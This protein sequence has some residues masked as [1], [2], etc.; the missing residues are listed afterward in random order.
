[1]RE[2]W[3]AFEHGVH[4]AARHTVLIG[5]LVACLT[6]A[7]ASAKPAPALFQLSIT[8]TAHAEW[9]HTGAVAAAGDCERTVRSEGIRN[10]SFR[11]A[12]STLVRVADGHVLAAKVRRLAGT[13]TL[14]GAN[15]TTDVCGVEVHEAIADCATTKRSFRGGT[16]DLASSRSP[17]LTFR[18]VRNVR[19]RTSSCPREPAQLARAPIGPVPASVPVSRATLSNDRLTRI[20]VTA[21]ARVKTT[22]GS[23]ESGTLNQRAVWKLE[24]RRVER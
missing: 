21:T 15:T 10:V 24:L 22:F 6:A 4:P 11:T 23:P 3:E 12:G 20:T 2:L 18:P 16:V 9:D 17:N 1:M 13:V 14:S 7:H 5:V 8:G 19:L